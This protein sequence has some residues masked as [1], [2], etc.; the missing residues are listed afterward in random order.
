MADLT[1]AAD[2]RVWGEAFTERYEVDSTGAQTIYRG[3]PIIHDM[4]LDNTGHVNPFVAAVVVADGDVSV[5]IAAENFSSAAAEVKFIECYV[6][7]TILGFKSTIFTNAD[8][9]KLVFPADSGLL[10]VTVAAHP[11]IGTLWRVDDGYAWI[12]LTR[13]YIHTGG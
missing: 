10:A 6:F 7:P 1:A 12:R 2:L 4:N 3:T 5:G 9:G 13:P 8:L 11:L